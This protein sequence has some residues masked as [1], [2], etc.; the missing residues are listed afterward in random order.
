MQNR[1][2]PQ[3]CVQPIVEIQ[4][5]GY[6]EFPKNKGLQLIRAVG[7]FWEHHSDKTSKSVTVAL[8]TSQ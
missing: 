1:V 6:E 8:G 4:G 7:R 3:L 2:Y 5:R